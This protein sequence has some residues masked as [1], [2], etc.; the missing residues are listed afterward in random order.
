MFAFIGKSK[1]IRHFSYGLENNFSIQPYNQSMLMYFQV[2]MGGD[3]IHWL[4]VQTN[5][6]ESCNSGRW[7]VTLVA[8][9]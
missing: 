8:A 4:F 3:L 2:E 1:G 5:V 9:R 7:L 6:F